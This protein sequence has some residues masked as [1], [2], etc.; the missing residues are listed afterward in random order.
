MAA[1][2]S[3]YTATSRWRKKAPTRVA[4]STKPCRR[5]VRH[6]TESCTAHR[7]PAAAL[8]RAVGALLLAAVPPEIRTRIRL[9][10]LRETG[11]APLLRHHHHHLRAS[12]DGA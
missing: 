8:F 1:S 9:P 6:C 5:L 10:H 7:R 2:I 12:D 3:A 11:A 4:S